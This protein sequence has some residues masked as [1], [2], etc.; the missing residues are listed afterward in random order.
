MSVNDLLPTPPSTQPSTPTSATPLSFS[1]ILIFLPYQ[2]FLPSLILFHLT[3][4]PGFLCSGSI[5]NIWI[6]ADTN[7][8][9][10]IS[11]L[12]TPARSAH[13]YMF[14]FLILSSILWR[15]RLEALTAD[16]K[17][18]G[19]IPTRAQAKWGYFLC[20]SDNGGSEL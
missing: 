20:P 12:E 7:R 17:V 14:S 1:T 15:N 13:I 11:Y 2:P 8:S 16:Q 3:F 19:S 4:H 9:T 10:N 18:W 6:Y 5:F